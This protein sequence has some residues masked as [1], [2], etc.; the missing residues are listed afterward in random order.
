[1]PMIAPV[2]RLTIVVGAGLVSVSAQSPYVI[3]PNVQVSLTQSSVQHYETQIA[4]DP[5]RADHLI[6]CA[7]IVRSGGRVDNVFYVS[8][9]HGVTWSHTLTVPAGTDPSCQI[10]L[11]GTAFAA[12][13]H[14]VS[15]S[16][17]H[18]DSFLVVHRSADGGRTW[19]ASSIAIDTRSVDRAY[20]SVDDSQGPRRGRLYVHGYL[21]DNKDAPAR[22]FR[23]HSSSILPRTTGGRSITR[24]CALERSRERPG[25]SPPTASW[26]LMEHL[27]RSWLNSTR[28]SPTCPIEPM[29]RRRQSLQ[30]AHSRSFGRATAV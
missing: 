18:S 15:R 9:D 2:A 26:R 21:Q 8:F 7:Y 22:L 28:R 16:D 13:I 30:T 10:G 6:A 19:K 27:S 1:M 14:D 3:G 29:R 12:S 23:L 17:G 11:K 25:F 4:T 20:L 5:E 24:S